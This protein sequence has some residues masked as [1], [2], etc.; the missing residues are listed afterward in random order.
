MKS[1]CGKKDAFDCA[2]IR[3]QVFRLPF[4]NNLMTTLETEEKKGDEEE[5][6]RSVKTAIHCVRF[7][8]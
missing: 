2:G 7:R 1:F 8:A 3:A 4:I 5:E 6:I